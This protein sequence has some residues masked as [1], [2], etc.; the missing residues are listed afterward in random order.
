[1]QL[2]ALPEP[3]VEVI[4]QIHQESQ[5]GILSSLDWVAHRQNQF[6]ELL[7]GF[8][9]NLRELESSTS[10]VI[11]NHQH[12]MQQELAQREA[13][14][15]GFAL[16]FMDEYAQYYDS[17][18]LAEH[19]RNQ[20]QFS[21][22]EQHL[23][24]MAGDSERKADLAERWL[25][26]AEQVSSF[27]RQNYHHAFHLPGVIAR[28][29][30]QLSLARDNLE[31]GMSEA[32]L[33]SAQ[34]VYMQLSEARVDLERME[35][36][37]QVLFCSAWEGACNIH[38][39]AMEN[40][41]A[42]AVDLDGAPVNVMLDVDYWTSGSLSNV[43]YEVE[44]LFKKMEDTEH[45]PS[46]VEL[47]RML[48]NQLPEIQDELGE[49]VFNA[50]VAAINSQLRINIA[51]LVVQA[52]Q[53]QGF[54]LEN[55]SYQGVDMRQSYA[56]RMMNFEGNEVE[57]QVAP[58][59][60]GIGENELH[61]RSFDEQLRTE[62]ELLQRWREINQSLA[63]RGLSVRQAEVVGA[64]HMVRENPRNRYS[65]GKNRKPMRE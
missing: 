36:E 63:Q 24:R 12:Q 20:D 56:A 27:I 41:E 65:V 9:E 21:Q 51:D 44:E 7:L 61:V 4:T 32:A 46:T 8:D 11:L 3:K 18:I 2:K 28:L 50:R 13:N 53:E 17:Q 40:Q 39:L 54:S 38:A 64:P 14:H 16:Q 62:H 25:L 5:E 6:T 22:Y 42:E 10:Q 52:L 33:L 31:N 35:A 15:W 48:K 43:F 26:S 57:I 59:G 47:R 29:E 37:W 49:A 58:Y 55:A 1:V 19:Q 60:S 30:Q 45:L 34:Q 23:N